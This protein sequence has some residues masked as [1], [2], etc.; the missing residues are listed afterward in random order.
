MKYLYVAN[1]KMNLSYRKSLDFC[2]QNRHHLDLLSKSAKIIICPSLVALAPITEILKNSAITIGAQDCSVHEA[3]S[4]TGEVSA[5][6]LKEAGA[7]YCIIGHSERRIYFGE[8][9]Q[10]I[11][12]KIDLIY[13]NGIIP[14]ICIGETQEDFLHKKTIAALQQQIDPILAKITQQKYAHAIIAYEPF[15]AVGTGIIPEKTYL[16][17]IFSWLKN[18][19][20]TH[21]VQLLYGGSINA[22]NI[23][24]LKAVKHIDGFLIGGASTD[25]REFQEI[26]FE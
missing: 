25:F 18:H 13:R 19:V 6:D 14:I 5:Q 3:G 2:T 15:W 9:T 17:E 4:Y 26:I 23:Q 10:D 22:A 24:Q 12:K 1:W 21:K 8:T 7:S 11:L 16:E 20:S